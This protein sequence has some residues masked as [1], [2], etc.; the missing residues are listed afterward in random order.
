MYMDDIKLFA[1]NDKQLEIMLQTIRL[2]SQD[3][4]ME[5]STE[6][7]AMLIMKSRDRETTE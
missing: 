4:R 1:E 3:I 6:K 2:Y 5:F 7:Y